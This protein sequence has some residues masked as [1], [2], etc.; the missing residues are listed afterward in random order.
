MPR[1]GAFAA[2]LSWRLGETAQCEGLGCGW[3]APGAA[4][5]L[6]EPVVQHLCCIFDMGTEDMY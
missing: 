1:K 4:C 3:S 2:A 6:T 5:L